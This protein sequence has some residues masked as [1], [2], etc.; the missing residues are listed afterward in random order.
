MWARPGGKPPFQNIV[1]VQYVKGKE[2]HMDDP[3]SSKV[4]PLLTGEEVAGRLCISRSLAYQLMRQGA[5]PT[6]QIGQRLVRVRLRDL[7]RYIEDHTR[8][9]AILAPDS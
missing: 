8:G 9:G 6:V 7:E 3:L 1:D 2:T 4:D 5:I